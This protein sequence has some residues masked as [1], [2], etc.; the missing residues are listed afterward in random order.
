MST[1]CP[2]DSRSTLLMRLRE[3]EEQAEFL[4]NA[5]KLMRRTN[6]LAAADLDVE[7]TL[8]GVARLSLPYSGVWTIVDVC[9]GDDVHRVSI[10]H[11]VPALRRLVSRMTGQWPPERDARSRARI[12]RTGDSELQARVTDEFLRALKCSPEHL[13]LLRQLEIGSVLTVAMTGDDG[14]IG[15]LTFL[16]PRGGRAFDDRD[17]RLAEDIAAG[18]AVAITGAQ[19]AAARAH[20][21]A[22]AE[23]NSA[24]RLS[25]MASLSHGVRTP[26]HNIFGYA[27]LLEAGIRGPLTE[28]Q[29]E[30]IGRIRENERHLLNLVD[31]VIN[32]A[33]WNDDEP[34]RIEDV[35][36]RDALQ[37]ADR[38]IV[39]FAAEKGVAYDSDHSEV[40]ADL[41]VRAE[42]LR[43]A[44]IFT[45]LLQNAV[46]FSR[47]GA[48]VAVRA[49]SVGECVWIRV[50]DTGIGIDEEDIALIFHPLVRGRDLYARVQ[51]G[52][53][54]G[55]AITRKL[56]RS[57]DG[58]L[59]VASDRDRGSTFTIALPRGRQ[60]RGRP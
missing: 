32:F 2:D 31:A 11:P 38:T 42:F 36:V 23:I 9:D 55:L 34:A 35:V 28:A 50:S 48:S 39:A 18:A 58:E 57:M 29:R 45:Q 27:Q 17:R 26:L 24:E 46:K 60:A 20:A 13:A 5:G 22:V 3:R 59:S 8:A 56:A 25:F 1:Q 51:D 10:S 14:I 40:P 37:F 49:M 47:P 19:V 53:G 15:S 21:R 16:S 30:D 44:E 6:K 12:L 52:V 54:L 41:V 43:L 4:F 7:S 33:R